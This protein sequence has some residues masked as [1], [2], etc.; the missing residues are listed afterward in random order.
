MG[1][2]L[3]EQAIRSFSGKQIPMK[4][5][6]DIVPHRANTKYKGQSDNVNKMHKT[7]I[8]IYTKLPNKTCKIT[9]QNS[10]WNFCGF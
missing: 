5:H 2:F 7:Y 8:N 1:D 9:I 3:T 10:G 6:P 4:K